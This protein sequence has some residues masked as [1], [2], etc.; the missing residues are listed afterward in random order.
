MKKLQTYLEHLKIKKKSQELSDASV[1][2]SVKKFS[3]SK[4]DEISICLKNTSKRKSFSDDSLVFLSS[5]SS[6]TM[7][8]NSHSI[9]ICFLFFRNTNWFCKQVVLAK[10]FCICLWAFSSSRRTRSHSVFILFHFIIKK[11]RLHLR[12][13]CTHLM[14]RSNSLST[15][16]FFCK[17]L[18]CSQRCMTACSEFICSRRSLWRK[19]KFFIVQW[20]DM[21]KK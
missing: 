17:R 14:Q 4:S 21:K 13:R 16:H 15:Q 10:I 11:V 5:F 8:W 12:L 7:F 2:V 18:Q 20:K 6:S 3:Q 1:I 9:I 19:I